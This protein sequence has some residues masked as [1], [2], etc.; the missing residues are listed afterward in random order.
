MMN[1]KNFTQLAGATMIGALLLTSCGASGNGNGNG[2]DGNGDAEAAGESAEEV[3]LRFA[4][5]GSDARHSTTQDIIDAFEEENP[6]ISVEAEYGDWGGYWDGLATQSAGGNPPDIIQMD[7]KYL[8]EYADRGALLEL[9][10]VDTSD[11]DEDAVNNGRTDEGLFGITTGINALALVANPTIFEEAGVD[12]PDDTSWTW[13]EFAE[14]AAE[15]SEN[16]DSAYGTNDPNEPGGFQVWLRQQDKHFTTDEGELGFDENDAAEYFQFY[17][18]MLGNGMPTASEISENQ[19]A[20]PDQ[21]LMGTGQVALAPWWTNQLPGLSEASGEDLELLRF[22][23]QSGNTDESGMWYKSSM[24]MSAS[25]STDHPE[26]TIAFIDWFV[27]SEE[28]GQLN[29]MDRGLLGNNSVRE[30]I[31][32]D[33][34]P[35]DARTAEF[36]ADI[37]TEVE[38][39]AAE[40]IPSLGFSGLQEILYRY[41]IQ[42]FFEEMTPE[43]AASSMISEMESE[44]Q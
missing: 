11:F 3:T 4:W 23:T 36:I 21:S 24:M 34:E 37:E 35:A 1:M 18:D 13:D 43:E 5:W 42:V 6:N 14:L 32:D 19:S 31:N 39:Q 20:G 25:A 17:Y 27:N 28:A 30:A 10:D 41:E 29:Q 33:L 16:H 40:P 44:I 38:A 7:D 2:N 15:I 12:M 26:E 8:R 9:S 22:P